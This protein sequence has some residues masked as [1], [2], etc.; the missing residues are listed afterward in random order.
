MPKVFVYGTLKTG[1]SNHRCIEGATLIGPATLMGDHHMFSLG[2]FPGV[3]E[4]LP[5]VSGV[6]IEGELYD[7][8]EEVILGPLDGLEG[9][10]PYRDDGMYLRRPALALTAD[11]EVV[12]CETYIYNHSYKELAENGY[13]EILSGVW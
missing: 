1:L 2:G 13:V 12:A 10:N 9:Y 7:A 6:A 11:D 3:V 5:G 4:S 8:P